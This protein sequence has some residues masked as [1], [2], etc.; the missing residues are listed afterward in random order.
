MLGILCIGRRGG[1]RDFRKEE[2]YFV[3]VY[4]CFS[5]QDL[6]SITSTAP[7]LS[8]KYETKPRAQKRTAPRPLTHDVCVSNAFSPRN[9]QLPLRAA[10]QNPVTLSL[11]KD[12]KSLSDGLVALLTYLYWDGVRRC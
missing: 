5:L 7:L 3:C 10:Q 9:M 1:V 11:A 8:P 4:F 2:R 6:L 12:F